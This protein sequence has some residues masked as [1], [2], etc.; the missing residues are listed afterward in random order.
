MH[1]RFIHMP[2]RSRTTVFFILG[3]FMIVCGIAVLVFAEEI[4][5]RLLGAPVFAAGF[6]LTPI[7]GN[8][9]FL[10]RD[11]DAVWRKSRK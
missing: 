10:N 4:L 6:G 8:R 2:T 11:P 5:I 3:I 7:A 1:A 9:L